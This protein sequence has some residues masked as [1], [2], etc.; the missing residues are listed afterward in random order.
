MMLDQPEK[1][2]RLMKAL[3]AALPF[4]VELTSSAI[5]YLRAQHIVEDVKPKQIVSKV[6]YTGDEGG[7]ICHILGEATENAIIISLTHLRIHRSHPVAKAVF[8]YQKHR[9]KKLKKQ[10]SYARL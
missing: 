7:I 9:V 2:A 6:F 10:G 5:A 3:E 4:E 8:E 1:T